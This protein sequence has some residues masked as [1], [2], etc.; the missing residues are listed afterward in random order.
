M[1]RKLKKFNDDAT[2]LL[3]KNKEGTSVPLDPEES[4]PLADIS[5]VALTW[6]YLWC[7]DWDRHLKTQTGRSYKLHTLELGMLSFKMTIH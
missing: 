4:F 5:T 3:W 6:L 1:F 7:R 2:Y